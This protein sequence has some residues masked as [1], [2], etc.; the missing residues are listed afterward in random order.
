M[1]CVGMQH[2]ESVRRLKSAGKTFPRTVHIT[3]TP[4]VV[5]HINTACQMVV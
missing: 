3:F 5:S 2:L 4:G 1:K